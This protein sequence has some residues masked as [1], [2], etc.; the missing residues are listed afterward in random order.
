MEERER[1]D[2]DEGQWDEASPQPADDVDEGEGSASDARPGSVPVVDEPLPT[3]IL[4]EG[5]R[6]RTGNRFI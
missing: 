4:A 5:A 1:A 3:G 2:P 6:V